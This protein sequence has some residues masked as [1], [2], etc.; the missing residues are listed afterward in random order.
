MVPS[1]SQLNTRDLTGYFIQELIAFTLVLMGKKAYFMDNLYDKNSGTM[2]HGK[3]RKGILVKR[4]PYCYCKKKKNQKTS[5]F[6]LKTLLKG[7]CV[8]VC[9]CVWVRETERPPYFP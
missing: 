2:D 7:V 1:W 4:S 3:G 9:V 5:C 6:I 8:C